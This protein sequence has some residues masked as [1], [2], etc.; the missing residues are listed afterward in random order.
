MSE[1][2]FE[3]LIDDDASSSKDEVHVE[4]SVFERYIKL[5]EQEQGSGDKN[6]DWQAYLSTWEL[7]K[8]QLLLSEVNVIETTADLTPHP[9]DEE[10][11]KVPG[12]PL[13]DCE[14][15]I[16]V[17]TNAVHFAPARAALRES[18][19]RMWRHTKLEK[20]V[21]FT[22][23]ML[24]NRVV[25]ELWYEDERASFEFPK[26][27]ADQVRELWA[28][29]IQ[30]MQCAWRYAVD[31][32]LWVQKQQIPPLVMF[33]SENTIRAIALYKIDQP[34]T[35][36]LLICRSTNRLKTLRELDVLMHEIKRDSWRRR[37]SWFLQQ[38]STRR[39]AIESESPKYEVT[40]VNITALRDELMLLKELVE[41]NKDILDWLDDLFWWRQPVLSGIAFYVLLWMGWHDL[42]WALAPA[43][44][45]RGAVKLFTTRINQSR[46][47]EHIEQE[48]KLE[49]A[50]DLA[51]KSNPSSDLDD[52]EI[53]AAAKAGPKATPH[54]SRFKQIRGFVAHIEDEVRGAQHKIIIVHRFVRE[55]N[56]VL[57]KLRTLTMCAVP[58]LTLTFAAVL[59]LIGTAMMFF[60]FQYFFMILVIHLFTQHMYFR[61]NKSPIDRFYDSIPIRED[62]VKYLEQDMEQGV[63]LRKELEDAKERLQENEEETQTQKKRK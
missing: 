23:G 58:H 47:L 54:V 24:S 18:R 7:K 34:E 14:G 10:K 36:P 30:E 42:Q 19:R 63:V 17:S 28:P 52:Q 50:K 55:K 35:P 5:L 16:F 39:R 40:E 15:S 43:F 62:L 46:E 44:L 37:V 27:M 25:L 11:P 4:Y 51:N 22:G 60:P 56:T 31:D 2:L 3:A 26:A 45:I 38:I 8:E 1:D 57:L 20:A 61:R 29:V 41:R 49:K 13:S 59:F 33:A 53:M 12:T 48:K 32:P 9:T 6:P 21:V